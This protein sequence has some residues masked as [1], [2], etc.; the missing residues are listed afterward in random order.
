MLMMGGLS[1]FSGFT[2]A[3]YAS[4]SDQQILDLVFA[5]RDSKGRVVPEYILEARGRGEKTGRPSEAKRELKSR[6]ELQI[7]EEAWRY[8]SP[9]SGKGIQGS[10][11]LLFWQIWRERGKSTD[12]IMDLWRAHAREYGQVL[13]D[14]K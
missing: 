3:V 8:G 12:E 9:H 14:K 11:V 7:P 2:P 5:E 1:G 13:L 6:E 10:F 4:L